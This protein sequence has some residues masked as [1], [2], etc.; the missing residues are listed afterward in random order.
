[1]STNRLLGFR[2]SP[3]YALISPPFHHHTHTGIWVSWR[4]KDPVRFDKVAQ[5]RHK[6]LDQPNGIVLKFL[7]QTFKLGRQKGNIER[8]HCGTLMPA[9]PKPE[10]IYLN[11]S[12]IHFIL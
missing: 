1:M 4:Y 6:G 9:N 11:I 8:C 3:G 2:N 12:S 5:N 10:P 7:K